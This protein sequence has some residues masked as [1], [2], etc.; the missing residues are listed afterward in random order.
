M[1]ME[2][3]NKEDFIEKLQYAQKVIVV[4]R[5]PKY[6]KI[7]L[8]TKRRLYTLKLENEQDL[9]DILSKVKVEIIEY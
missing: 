8:R 2:I 1:P 3:K 7:K 5:L 9:H 4:N 6:A